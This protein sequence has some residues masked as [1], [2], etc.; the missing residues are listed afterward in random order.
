VYLINSDDDHFWLTQALAVVPQ[1]IAVLKND[2]ALQAMIITYRSSIQ[3]TIVYDSSLVDTVNVA[4]TL[5]GQRDGIVASPA[6]A[7]KLQQEHGLP[8]L[9]DLRKHKWRTRTQAYNWA[10]QNL[11][12]TASARL[13]AGLDPTNVNGLRSFLVATRTFVYWLDPRK[14]L[15]GLS[16]GLLSERALMQA[17]LSHFS[18]ATVHL[19]WFI[20]EGS[21]VSLTSQAGIPV[22]ASD[23]FFNLETWTAVQPQ[24]LAISKHAAGGEVPSP[25][26]DKVY[27]SFTMSDGDNLQY[28]QHRMLHLWHDSNRGSLPIGWTLS[29]AI[30]EAAP[31][32]ANYYMGSA[33]HNDEL[34]GG[35]SG[36]GYIFP[37]HWPAEQLAPFLQRTGQ[38]MQS[39]N[40]STLQVLDTDILHSAGLPISMSGMTFTNANR[41]HEYVQVLRPFGVR[42]ILSG[43]GLSTTSIKHIDS[44]PV[45]QN[46]GLASNIARTVRLIKNAASAHAERPLFLNVYILAWSMTPSD[47]R[48][49]V[50]Q[51][52]SEY[53]IVLPKTLWAM[54]DTGF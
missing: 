54:L 3:G 10:R 21:G 47:L 5:A 33:T 34:I 7:Q 39:M 11:L 43:A 22:L 51:L 52:G 12:T 20:A 28:C 18:A 4:T 46:L 1:D 38:L 25:V 13:V 49:V 24:Q 36:A 42:G 14:Y 35:P 9:E 8:V 53:E 26:T 31:A 15:P 30:V 32:M 17:I 16:N 44:V 23:F 29:P 37:S 27:V 41:H 40:M 48:Q 19:G 2:D 45:L 50:Q 6:L